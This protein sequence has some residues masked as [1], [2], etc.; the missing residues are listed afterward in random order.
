MEKRSPKKMAKPGNMAVRD[1]IQILLPKHPRNPHRPIRTGMGRQNN[2]VYNKRALPAKLQ[3][4]QDKVQEGVLRELKRIQELF[5][6]V[7]EEDEKRMN[8]INSV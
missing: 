1:N 3:E 5:E 4:I 2:S 7:Y 6:G 8:L